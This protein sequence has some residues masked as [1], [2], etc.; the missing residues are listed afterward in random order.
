[1]EQTLGLLEVYQSGPLTVVGFGGR[2][3]VDQFNLAEYR[4]ELLGLMESHG[5]HALAIDLTGVQ[6]L[7]SG[8]LGILASL[9]RNGVKVSLFNACDTIRE[10]LEITHLDQILQLHEVEI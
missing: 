2:E 9:H 8:L 5:C 1:M 6:I 7:P 3:I 10:V 4:D